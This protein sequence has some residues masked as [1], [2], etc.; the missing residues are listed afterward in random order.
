MQPASANHVPPRHPVRLDGVPET[1]LWTLYNRAREAM[2]FDAILRDP[3]AIR[4]YRSIEYDYERSFGKPD[5]SHA[6]RSRIFDDALRP[7]L[8]AHPGFTVVEL[9]CGLETQFQRCDDGR[10]RW[11]CVDVPEVIELRARLLPENRRCLLLAGSAL[12]L[13]WLDAIDPA[14]EVFVSAQGL[15]MYFEPD[16]VRDLL[17]TLDRRLPGATLMFDTIPPWFSR[18]TLAGFDKTPHY[19]APPMPWGIARDAIEPTL[20]TWM[21]HARR[22][23]ITPFGMQRGLSGRLFRLLARAPG[24]RA[25]PPNI[26]RVEIGADPSP[27]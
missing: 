24:L 20:R 27:E 23:D 26:V 1:L 11:I 8:A 15:F 6:M 25:L 10:V 16:R 14:R 22:I 5:I 13:D 2:R 3:E 19:R 4:L 7:W 17:A 12:D 9:A 18:K 21:P